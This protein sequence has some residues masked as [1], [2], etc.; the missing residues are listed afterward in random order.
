[1]AK[2]VAFFASK[3]EV[4]EYYNIET[5]K[6][7]LFEPHYNLSPGHQLP[8]ISLNE[9]EPDINRIRWGKMGAS[10][11]EQTTVKKE[12]V[13]EELKKDNVKR[14]IISLSGFFVWKDDQEKNHPFFVRLLN[15]A[16]M[17]VAGLYYDDDEPFVSL[18]TTE[19][20]TLVQPMS[21]RMPLMFDRPTAL[22]W[23]DVGMDI[24]EL[25][26]EA[27]NLFMLTDL[28]VLRVSKKVNDPT[29][30]SAEIIQPIPK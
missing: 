28:S 7:A 27:D 3:E 15:N 30:N 24:S 2:R 13:L 14:S 20:N 25:L 5:N 11:A 21:P 23:L 10:R 19:A 9:G 17:S 6:E 22:Q 12:K 16:V 29:N 26:E 8:V 1:M 18:I 4:E